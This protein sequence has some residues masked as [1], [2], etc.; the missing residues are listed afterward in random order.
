MRREAWFYEAAPN[1]RV[2]CL[3]CPHFCQLAEGQRGRCGVRENR[4]G[5]L[6]LLVYG[7]A[8][9]H[10]V[11]PIEKKPLFHV[12][13]GTKVLSV[14]TV[15]CNLRCRFCQNWMISQRFKGAGR[16]PG[17]ELPP[18]RA[19]KEAQERGCAGV[20]CTYTEPTVFYEYAWDLVRASRAAGLF[21]V[22][23]TNGY[24]TPEPLRRL[25]PY[26]TAAN[27]DLKYFSAQTYRE[28]SGGQLEPVLETLKW[29]KQLGVWVEVTTLVLP[30]INDSEAEL[31]RLAEFIAGELG[32][33]TP[34]H[35]S[36]FHP[37]YQLT[38]LPPT[39]PETLRRAH[40]IGLKAGL[41]YVYLDGLPGNP[42]ESTH[43]S[44]CGERLIHRFGYQVL[45]NRL[46]GGTCP[47]CGTPLDGV[48][49]AGGIPAARSKI[50]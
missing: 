39:P 44:R 31:G 3:L 24:L 30:G 28:V 21:T 13:P 26:L 12:A 29:L 16:W 2:R 42:A 6:E 32:V 25:A 34:W 36:R 33:E 14:A 50:Q 47:A 27:V 18:E 22:W 4:E 11:D 49:L 41:R 10:S 7:W 8:V 43:C 23:V 15:G 40:T 5:R 9:A 37:D 20:A 17:E 45:A 48:E 1:G 46:R 19:V 38:E 35:L